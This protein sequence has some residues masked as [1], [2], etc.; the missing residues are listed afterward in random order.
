MIPLLNSRHKQCQLAS[1]LI[2]LVFNLTI[3]NAMSAAAG[4]NTNK[5]PLSL[6]PFKPSETILTDYRKNKGMFSNAW[7][8]YTSSVK[9]GDRTD[10]FVEVNN[11]KLGPFTNNSDLFVFSPNGKKVVFAAI[12]RDGN[13]WHVYENGIKKWAHNGFAWRRYS[14][15]LG[16]KGRMFVSQT[17]SVEFKCSEDNQHVSYFVYKDDNGKTQ[18]ANATDG[19]EGRYYKSIN[20]SIR[21]INGKPGYTAEKENN[22]NYFVVGKQE[23]GPYDKTYGIK[24]SKNREHFSFISER[25]DKTF[26]VLNGKE[27][28]IPGEYEGHAISDKGT[29]AFAYKK[30]SKV[31]VR[32][33]NKPWPKTYDATLW[34]QLKTSPDGNTVAGWFKKKGKWYVS[35]NGAKE[36][37]PYGSHFHIKAGQIYSLFLGK[38]GENVSYLVRKIKDNSTGSE[39]FL[40]GQKVKNKPVFGGLSISYTQDD[41][42]EVVGLGKMGAIDADTMAVADATAQGAENPLLAKY[43]GNHLVYTKRKDGKTYVINNKK[44]FGPFEDAGNFSSSPDGKHYTF[45]TREKDGLR[46]IVD[47]KYHTPYYK[48]IYKLAFSGNDEI[49]FLTIKDKKVVRI[50]YSVEHNKPWWKLW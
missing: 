9:N 24:L 42:G 4:I 23:Y 16:L 38:S 5:Q 21:F 40:N 13:T 12:E 18:W 25:G 20:S 1:S 35:V 50:A 48:S 26:L 34:H 33:N 45:T 29:V 46:V 27:I 8:V 37:G 17:K 41:A 11:K 10:W 3:T 36:Y 7:V 31:H 49:A 6:I 15:P 2:L 19:K 22:K 47:G 28:Q 32:H 43:T 30:D 44:M 39:Y 14:W